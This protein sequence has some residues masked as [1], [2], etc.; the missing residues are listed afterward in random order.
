MNRL[1]MPRF[2]AVL[3]VLAMML[4]A[5]ATPA[6]ADPPDNVTC[7]EN[8][9]DKGAVGPIVGSGVTPSGQTHPI[10]PL[11]PKGNG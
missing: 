2:I 7:N 1:S 4:V 10:C 5:T 6:L 11:T 3:V 9:A 8:S